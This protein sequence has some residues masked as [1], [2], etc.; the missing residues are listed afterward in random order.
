MI[1]SLKGEIQMEIKTTP[2]FALEVARKLIAQ[3]SFFT[4]EHTK[5]HTIVVA[6]KE[7]LKKAG[8]FDGLGV[9]K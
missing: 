3:G 8:K 1:A 4:L 5:N 6:S 7:D 9:V 2:S